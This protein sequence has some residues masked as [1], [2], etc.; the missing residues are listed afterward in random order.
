MTPFQK[1]VRRRNL[2]IDITSLLSACALLLFGLT[3]HAANVPSRASQGM[4][5]SANAQSSQ[6]GVD[7]MRAGGNAI[8][9]SVAVAFA[10]AVTHPTAGN[11][12]GGGFIIYQPVTVLRDFRQWLRVEGNQVNFY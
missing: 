9:A 6:I 5:V 8:D 4:V 12:G 2:R 1:P 3:A 11:I 10:L 7:V